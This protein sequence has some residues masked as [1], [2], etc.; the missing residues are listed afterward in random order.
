MYINEISEIYEK[1]TGSIEILAMLLTF[2]GR[3]TFQFEEIKTDFATVNSEFIS[4]PH[5]LGYRRTA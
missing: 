2:D 4:A 1:I 5:N 3:P